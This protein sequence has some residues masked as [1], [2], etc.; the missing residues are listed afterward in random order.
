LSWRSWARSVEF[1]LI[2]AALGLSLGHL[3]RDTVGLITL[4]GLIT[5]SASTYLIIYSHPL[6]ERLAPYLGVFERKVAH[7][8]LDGSAG[9]D[10]NMDV[11]LFG[12]GRYGAAVAMATRSIMAMPKIRNSL[13][14]CPWIRFNGS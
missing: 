1:S 12:L 6:Y 11:L 8:E 7:R 9:D 13:P 2:L 10:R 5:I 4:V 14:R 3:D